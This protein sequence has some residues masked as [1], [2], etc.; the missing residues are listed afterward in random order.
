MS[1]EGKKGFIWFVGRCRLLRLFP[2]A[3]ATRG[4][5]R[6]GL[7]HWLVE[8]APPQVIPKLLAFLDG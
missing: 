3:R 6:G 7:L 2:P 4:I 1:P 8:A 5:K